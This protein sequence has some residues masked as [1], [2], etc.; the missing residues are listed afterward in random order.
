MKR[1]LVTGPVGRLAD[2]AMAARSAGWE[3]IEA[4]LLCVQARDFRPDE[5]ERAPYDWICITSA[6]ALP[7]LAAAT[8]EVASLRTTPCA[9]VGERTAE[10]VRALGLSIG[11]PAAPDAASL[12]SVL[13]S[14]GRAPA[15]VLWPR[16]NL[17]E[18]LAQRLRER[19]LDVED[20]VA[21]ETRELERMEELPSSSA[22]FF[23]SASAVRAWH[24]RNDEA[25][26][27]GAPGGQDP[28]LA[29]AIAIGRA[30]LEALLLETRARFFS[31]ITLPQP[32]PEALGAI[33]AHLDPE[34]TS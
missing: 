26:E 27:R 12:A 6:N 23:A 18:E 32:T 29:I 4:P 17:S 9:V 8:G 22:I 20:P 15:R 5:L 16:G 3:A 21:Y 33:L 28:R 7:W 10:R 34:T 13:G 24:A 1:V 14:P 19:G 25:G 31:T 30:T 2:Y 11:L